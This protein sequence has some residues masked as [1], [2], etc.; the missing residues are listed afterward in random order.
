MEEEHKY[1]HESVQEILTWAQ[2]ILKNKAYPSE[3]FQLD[4][5]ARIVDC[6]AFLSTMIQIISKNW[7]NPT[8][9]TAID[10]LREFRLKLESNKEEV[11]I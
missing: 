1:D 7:E 10:Q 11:A 6:G 4:K 2:D 5:A 8:F 9:N 3:E